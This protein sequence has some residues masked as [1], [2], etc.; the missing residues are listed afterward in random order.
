MFQT[1]NKIKEKN[2]LTTPGKIQE[3]LR[4][5]R[6]NTG[7]NRSQRRAAERSLQKHVRQFHIFAEEKKRTSR[8]RKH[9]RMKNKISRISRRRNCA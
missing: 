5:F 3:G 1:K 6:K 8:I 9:N 2:K 4:Y 7:S